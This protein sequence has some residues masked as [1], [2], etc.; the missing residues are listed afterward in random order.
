MKAAL[1]KAFE[2]IGCRRVTVVALGGNTLFKVSSPDIKKHKYQMNEIGRLLMSYGMM[3]S[4]EYQ[5][6][7]EGPCIIAN[8]NGH[9]TV[10]YTYPAKKDPKPYG[11][12]EW[13]GHDFSYWG[14]VEK[15]A[16]PVYLNEPTKTEGGF[17][18]AYEQV[19][20][21]FNPVV[22]QRIADQLSFGYETLDTWNVPEAPSEKQQIEYIKACLA[23][24]SKFAQKQ[25]Q[26]LYNWVAERDETTGDGMRLK[27]RASLQRVEL[28][29]GEGVEL[30]GTQHRLVPEGIN[31]WRL[32]GPGVRG[33]A[34]VEFYSD[35]P[36]PSINTIEVKPSQR[37]WGSKMIQA[38]VNHYGG[39][40]SDPQAYTSAAAAAMWE[41]LGAEKIPSDKSVKGY[42]YQLVKR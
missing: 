1:L 15:Q 2:L 32:E 20:L 33:Y 29:L 5:E 22:A 40:L 12:Q 9:N 6:T 28:D 4:V 27:L 11:R 13:T 30:V 26:N 31:E 35:L 3:S 18:P 19:D 14:K 23:D 24:E 8:M 16:D 17:T 41:S 34:S 37:G 42:Y 21:D 39:L 10:T 38:M 25:R 36:F 7:D